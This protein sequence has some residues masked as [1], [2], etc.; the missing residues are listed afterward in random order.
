ME[1]LNLQRAKSLLNRNYSVKGKVTLAKQSFSK[2]KPILGEHLA[3]LNLREL[4]PRLAWFPFEC[5]HDIQQVGR[6]GFA[7]VYSATVCA[8]KPGAFLDRS[9]VALKTLDEQHL[10]EVSLVDPLL[11]ISVHLSNFESGFAP[12]DVYGIS[13]DDKSGRYLM[14]FQYAAGGNLEQQPQLSD[15]IDVL[16]RAYYLACR[17]WA[18]HNR[19]NLLLMRCW[20]TDPSKRPSGQEVVQLLS[21]MLPNGIEPTAQPVPFSPM[22]LEFIAER[23]AMHRQELSDPDSFAFF[24]DRNSSRFMTPEELSRCGPRRLH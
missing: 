7:T 6:G 2:Y 13:Q 22:T 16:K 14:V 8:D 11:L 15:W 4:S 3:R 17:L 20:N 12:L 24:T 9:R 18:M 10:Q 19:F 23:H 5:F 1:N 21:N